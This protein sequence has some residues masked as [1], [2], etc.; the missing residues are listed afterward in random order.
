MGPNN[1]S[2][3]GRFAVERSDSFDVQGSWWHLSQVKDAAKKAGFLVAVVFGLA[4]S[5]EV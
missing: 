3:G 5:L 1:R 2:S 4:G